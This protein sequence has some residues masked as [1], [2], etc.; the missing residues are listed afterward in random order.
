[1]LL[2]AVPG[3]I[4]STGLIATIVVLA[5]PLG[6]VEA[7]LLG[8]ILSAT[9]HMGVTSLLRR[10]GAPKR[11][12]ILVDGESLFNDATAIVLARILQGILLTVVVANGSVLFQGGL[13]FLVVF[14]G[15]MLLGWAS[16]V[17][18]GMIL[19]RVD[20]DSF[21]EVTLTTVLAYASFLVAEVVLGVSGVP[22][23]KSV[24]VSDDPP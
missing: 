18:V 7:L 17:L 22:I 14:F 23:P 20:G 1:M 12:T 8:S 15:G 6:W 24:V 13:Q 5:T 2:L 4:L 9:E 10:L 11:L 3:L 19:G 16:A 21:I